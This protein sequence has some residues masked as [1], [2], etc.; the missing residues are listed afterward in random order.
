MRKGLRGIA[1]V[2]ALILGL[3]CSVS[4]L[5]EG[6]KYQIEE[7]T[8]DTR[9]SYPYKVV[10]ESAVLYLAKEDIELLGEEAF[11]DGMYKL[12]ENMDRDFADAREVMKGFLN[13]EVAPIPI[14]TAFTGKSETVTDGGDAEYF[15]KEKRIIRLYK[16]WDAAVCGLLHEYAHYLTCS[17]ATFE[18]TTQAWRE[19]IAEYISEIACRNNMARSNNYGMAEQIREIF[20]ANGWVDEKGYPDFRV[21]EY[22]NYIALIKG[23][24]KT[25]IRDETSRVLEAVNLSGESRKKIKSLSGGMKQRVMRAQAMTGSPEILILDE[26]SAGLDPK[27]RVRM[28]NLIAEMSL[29]RTV[30]LATHIVSDIEMLAD[31]VI[32]LK[33]GRTVACGNM[34]DIR[35][36][37]QGK[38][39]RMVCEE[40]RYH[41][42]ASGR[43]V[44]GIGKTKDGKVWLRFISDRPETGCEECFPELEDIYLYNFRDEE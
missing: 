20:A 15:G 29:N 27:E 19:C 40:S 5:G 43:L 14:Y 28:R 42:E 41:Q 35:K 10:T 23:L 8:G 37:L 31:R 1:F 12:L 13:G 18:I 25:E 32:I 4:A 44:S 30:I 3:C 9:V 39:F 16:G 21:Y 22:L 2:M 7:N 36:S 17:C 6:E 26:P 11:Y 38:V 33:K 24:K 34:L